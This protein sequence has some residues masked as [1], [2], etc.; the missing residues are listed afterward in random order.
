MTEIKLG[1]TPA[2]ISKYLIREWGTS[3]LREAMLTGREVTPTELQ[4]I[5]AV[6]GISDNTNTLDQMTEDYLDRLSRCAPRSAAAC[7]ELIRLGWTDPGGR[8]Q[9]EKIRHTFDAMMAPGSEGRFG[10]EQF[11]KKVKGINWGH[12]WSGR[13]VKL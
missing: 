4:R 3:F 6:H 5:G 10:I 2:I 1:L 7:K 8:K 9:D 12:F 13:G 11:Q